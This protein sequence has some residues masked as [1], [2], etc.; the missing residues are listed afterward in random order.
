MNSDERW[1]QVALGLALKGQGYVEPNPMVGCVVVRD[2]QLI[3]SGFH[4][5]FGGPHAEVHALRDLD[6]Q[7]LSE[8]TLYVTLEPCA[9]HGKTPPC[10]DLLLSKPP[11]R[12]VIA[13]KDPFEKVAGVGISRLRQAGV[14]VTLGV[15]EAQSKELNAP[16]LKRLSEGLPWVIAKWA[17]SLDGAI[18]SKTGDSKWISNQ[19][20]R[21][22]VHRLRARVD[23]ILVG[24]QTVLADDPLLTAR[25]GEGQELPRRALRVVLD[26]RFRISVTSQLVRTARDVP[27]LVAVNR[28]VLEKSPEK[29]RELQ[30]A[31]VS[32]LELHKEHCEEQA[33]GLRY[34][35]ETICKGGATNVLIEGGAAVLGSFL[36][37]RL[38]DQVECYIAP[39]II[40]GAMAHRPVC[41]SGVESIHS[42]ANFRHTS[43]EVL[44]GD[45]HFSGFVARCQPEN[46]ESRKA[47]NL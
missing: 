39:K 4:E 12:V 18:A 23:A 35:L 2:E 24:S 27:L 43:W 1:M 40:G 17:M 14:A 6:A 15:L 5:R 31:G 10:V 41:G 36:D 11:K 46:A 32:I 45:L 33:V 38:V 20:S 26:R 21:D 3:A 22:Q 34:L 28:E 37:A 19:R 47:P 16:Y 25:L 44:E 42:A 30:Q 29:V 7:T 9:H 8:S 13:M